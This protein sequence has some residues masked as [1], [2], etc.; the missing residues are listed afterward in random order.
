MHAFYG[1][2]AQKLRWSELRRRPYYSVQYS[3][4]ANQKMKPTV[5]KK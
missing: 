2:A 5:K 4:P 3:A 1:A